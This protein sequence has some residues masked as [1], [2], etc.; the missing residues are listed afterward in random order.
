MDS[1]IYLIV[2]IFIFIFIFLLLREF[3]CWY[4]K[5]NQRVA[6]MEEIVDLLEDIKKNTT[7]KPTLVDPP[8]PPAKR[9]LY[10]G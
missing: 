4:H 2:G 1:L 8:K 5:I 7:R 6:L 9:V 3:F 10:N